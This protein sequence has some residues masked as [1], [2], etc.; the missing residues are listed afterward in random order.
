MKALITG[1]SSGLGR[2]FAEILS[3]KGYDLI[4]VS[5]DKEKL[6]NVKK[7]LNTNIE[8]IVMDLSIP[9]NCINLYELVKNENIDIIINNAGFGVFGNFDETS[10]EKELNL[11]ETNIS[12]VH[13]LT[14]LFYKKF[15]KEDKGYILNVSS[16]AA[17][18]PG[19]LMAAYY[20]SKSYVYNL[21]CAIHEEAKRKH[22]KL[23]ISVLCPGPVNTNF[24][25]V[26]NVQFS[27]K[28]LESYD[29]ANY[30]LKKMFRNKLLI[31][32]GFTIKLAHFFGKFIP[33][34]LLNKITYNIQ[35]KKVR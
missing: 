31:I 28:A 16:S 23:R 3:C 4:L 6:D 13:I 30:A 10:L 7:K 26:A 22:S 35:K 15:I 1:A 11:I 20:A 27:V 19:P 34:N 12:A 21:T 32:P 29:V 17:F 8:I 9:R 25:N 18:E 33:I 14:K 2:N 24:N 5:R